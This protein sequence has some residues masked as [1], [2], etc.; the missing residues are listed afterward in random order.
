MQKKQVAILD[1]NS[2]E[3]VAVFGERGINNTFIIKNRCSYK[4]DGFSEGVFFNEEE[5]KILV[6]KAVDSLIS[7]SKGDLDTVFVGVPG[8]FSEVLVRD[9]QISFPSKKKI[10]EEDEDLLYDSAFVVK[11]K[12]Y[13][14]INRSAIN[15]ELDDFRRVSNPI[16]YSS[17]ILK[18][19]LSFILCKNYFIELIKTIINNKGIPF[20]EWVS[21]SLAE[22]IY[23]LED[24]VRD[25]MAVIADVGH[26]STTISIVQGDGL[27]YQNAFSFG[28]GFISA[29][30]AERFSLSFTESEKIKEKINLC[31]LPKDGEYGYVEIENGQF[32]SIKEI[33]SIANS[34]L[35]FLCEKITESLES[36][37]YNLPE[38]VTL[39]ITGGG[40]TSL[41]GGKEHI[42]NRLGMATEILSPK[43]PLM[44]RPTES[45]VLSLL[46]IA[47]KQ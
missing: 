42:S 36:C 39:F 23:L 30:I 8:E 13:T 12:N 6:G 11:S 41:R 28:G 43:V 19:K 38:Y 24:E 33:N 27:L 22:S 21:I 15:Y 45:S 17:E 31:V 47:L 46:D 2:S 3:I 7:V 10:R 44:E 26:I 37:G 35:D 1:I 14:L 40:V 20:V 16:G 32:L 9:S 5:L 18:G 4:Y 25:R 29:G 34:N